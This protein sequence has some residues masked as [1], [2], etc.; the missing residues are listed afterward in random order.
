MAAETQYTANTV[1]V[2][3]NTGNT[4]LDGT[5][6]NMGTVIT[7]ASYGTLIKTLTCKAQ[8]NTTQGMLRF[9]VYDG[10]YTRLFL[11]VDVPAI[12]KSSNDPTFEKT[13]PLN[14]T[15][16]SGDS[17]LVATHNS[18]TFNIIAEGQNWTYYAN[19]VRAETTQYN[20][21]NPGVTISTA[22]TYLDGS[23]TKGTAVISSGCN[24]MAITIKAKQTTTPGM[25]RIFIN[26][27][28]TDN[29]TNTKLFR[30]IP[31][32]AVT[33]SSIA[34]YF[35]HK[36]TF[37]NAFALKSGWKILVSTEKAEAFNVITEALNWTYPA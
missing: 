22:N 31:V 10:T 27:G 9:F 33:P 17:L 30:E 13:I 20:H 4:N 18:E 32:P 16:K 37:N 23:G 3:I 24:V 21:N 34:P 26:N 6:G 8:G 29:S 12:T 5:G 15:L 14:F 1:I 19:S 25:V 11:E 2:T 35:Y 7:G 28:S 36:L